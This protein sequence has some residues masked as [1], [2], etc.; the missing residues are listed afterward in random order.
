MKRVR[1]TPEELSEQIFGRLNIY[2]DN[3]KPFLNPELS[4]VD[5]A[6]AIYTNKGYVGRSV[7][8]STGKSFSWFVMVK[9]LEYARRL[10]SDDPTLLVYQLAHLSGFKSVSTFNTS[11]K[12]YYGL[13][14]REW[15]DRY[16]NQ[17]KF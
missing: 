17:M 10:F 11:F 5:V 12:S 4:E 15:C 16:R 14:P 7:K 13:G 1:I 8:F 9:R 3:E 6:K 2:F